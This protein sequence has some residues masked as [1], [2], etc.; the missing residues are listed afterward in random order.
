MESK[1]FA[2][3]NLAFRE[4]FWG[5]LEHFAIT[6]SNGGMNIGV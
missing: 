4:R 6:K 3:E 5:V 2:E 1:K